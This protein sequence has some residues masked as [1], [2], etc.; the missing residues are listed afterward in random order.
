VLWQ[1][2]QRN[3]YWN[4]LKNFVAILAFWKVKTKEYHNREMKE[5]STD[6]K[7]ENN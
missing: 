7:S 2:G 5:S 4:L 6:G 1:C 3:F